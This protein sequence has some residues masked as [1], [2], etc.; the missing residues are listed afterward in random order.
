VTVTI[1]TATSSLVDTVGTTYRIAVA[2]YGGATG[3]ATLNW[4]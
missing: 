1:D 2:G 3:S 4:R